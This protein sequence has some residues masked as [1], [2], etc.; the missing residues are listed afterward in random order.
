MRKTYKH[1][2]VATLQV[3]VC[4]E[5]QTENALRQRAVYLED[6]RSSLA[7]RL[8]TE[9]AVAPN[10]VLAA[11]VNLEGHRELRHALDH[12]ASRDNR[13]LSTIDADHKACSL[14][15]G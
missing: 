14:H 4:V 15:N 3:R 7:I 13:G 12:M 2:L 5:A 10:S 6:S 11:S 1:D 8:H 9:N